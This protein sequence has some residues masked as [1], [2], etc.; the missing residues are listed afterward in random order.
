LSD[1]RAVGIKA[2]RKTTQQLGVLYGKMGSKAHPDGKILVAYRAARRAVADAY[3]QPSRSQRESAIRDAL[4]TLRLSLRGA[5]RELLSAAYQLGLEQASQELEARGLRPA[6]APIRIAEDL[7][8]WEKRWE[9]Q[10]AWVELQARN[11]AEPSEI[12]GD[13]SRVGSLSAAP[14]LGLGALLLTGAAVRGWRSKV[15]ATRGPKPLY[16]WKQ[17]VA[18]IDHRTTNCC[19]GV[20]GQAQPLQKPFATHGAPHFAEKQ[21]WAPFHFLCRTVVTLLL[22][23]EAHDAHTEALRAEA[24]QERAYRKSKAS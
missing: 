9:A 14:I 15:Q 3:G 16:W 18:T 5:G 20:H 10:L 23:A 12:V 13:R 17:A 22:E 21:N 7:D 19:L 2:A 24:R 1:P 11:D 4:A 6:I 8:A